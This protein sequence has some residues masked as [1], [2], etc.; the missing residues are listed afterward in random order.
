MSALAGIAKRML[1]FF[2]FT[3]PLW[4]GRIAW[5]FPQSAMW[6]F[7]LLLV[8]LYVSPQ[9]LDLIG[10]RAPG[11]GSDTSIRSGETAACTW[12]IRLLFLKMLAAKVILLQTVHHFNIPPADALLLAVIAGQATGSFGIFVAHEMLHGRSRFDRFCAELLMVTVSY[13]HFCIEHI[14]GHHRNV[15]T[16]LDPATARWHESVYAFIPRSVFGGVAGAWRYETTR[17]ARRGLGWLNIRNRMLRYT[18]WIGLFYALVFA[19]YG[20]LGVAVMLVQS[21]VAIF[22]LETINYVQHYGLQRRELA[23]GVFEPI[24]PQHSWN[25]EF[26]FSN[27]YWLNLGRHSDHHFAAERKFA[28]LRMHADEPELP[29]GLVT[30]HCVALIPPLWFKVMDPR[31]RAWRARYL[32]EAPTAHSDTHA[33]SFAASSDD[34]RARKTE[35]APQGWLS[36]LLLGSAIVLLIVIATMWGRPWD[37]GFLVFFSV[38]AIA[39]RNLAAGR[40]AGGDTISTP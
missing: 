17:L 25:T 32:D 29:A 9:L 35:E 22:T 18:F 31:V 27:R 21:L 12:T 3:L 36:L 30:M 14:H 7:A 28:F 16:R 34:H 39:L 5:T 1:F 23:P 15:S 13:P 11:A 20:T 4:F 10:G 2:P 24:G 26:L 8:Y 37:I 40:D 33:L 19:I 6:E 38:L